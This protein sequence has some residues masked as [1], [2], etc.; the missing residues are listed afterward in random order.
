MNTLVKNLIPLVFLVILNV[1]SMFAQFV[2]PPGSIWEFD[3]SQTFQ[4]GPF[5]GYTRWEATDQDTLYKGQM[6]QVINYLSLSKEYKSTKIDTISSELFFRKDSLWLA[7]ARLPK[8]NGDR[9]TFR[10]IWLLDGEDP[11][12]GQTVHTSGIY[13]PGIP[14]TIQEVDT[15]ELM[16]YEIQRYTIFEWGDTLQVYPY[17]G[18]IERND[19]YLQH[20]Y[21]ISELFLPIPE[22]LCITDAGY[23]WLA[24]FT[25]PDGTKWINQPDCGHLISSLE[26]EIDKQSWTLTPNPTTGITGLSVPGSFEKL[27]IKLYTLTGTEA[28]R[29]IVPVQEGNCEFDVSGIAAGWYLLE[30]SNPDGLQLARIPL[31]KS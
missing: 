27:H 24:C 21:Y 2:F 15:V 26:D 8:K 17:P 6:W 29:F 16:G 28:A 30:I 4:S 7:V 14:I 25:F 18:L 20:A 5:E 23:S 22:L 9:D 12:P 19:K 13:C 3:L 10:H 1:P 31:I 11:G